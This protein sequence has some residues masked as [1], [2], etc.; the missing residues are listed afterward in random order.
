VLEVVY[1]G[2]RRV[3]DLVYPTHDIVYYGPDW[4]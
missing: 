2:H 1:L 4:H 3:F